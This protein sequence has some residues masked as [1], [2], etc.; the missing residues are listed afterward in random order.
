VLASRRAPSLLCCL[1]A[2]LCNLCKRSRIASRV[3]R[4]LVFPVRLSLQQPW[5]SLQPPGG[6]MQSAQAIPDE[7]SLLPPQSLMQPACYTGLSGFTGSVHPL[8]WIVA[9]LTGAGQYST[10]C[11][12]YG[13]FRRGAPRLISLSLRRLAKESLPEVV[14]ALRRF[15][16]SCTA[17]CHARH[18]VFARFGASGVRVLVSFVASDSGSLLVLVV[19]V[20]VFHVL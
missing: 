3:C 16:F 5:S 7:S 18:A 13:V 10:P 2:V 20:S 4:R 1:L 11:I 14:V 12:V 17:R 19:S 9:P 6:L 8:G 15:S